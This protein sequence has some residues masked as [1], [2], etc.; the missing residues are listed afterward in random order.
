MGHRI[1]CCGEVASAVNLQVSGRSWTAR[2]RMGRLTD[3]IDQ[4]LVLECSAH[5]TSAPLVAWPGASP[6]HGR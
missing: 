5:H 2:E 4:H 6:F 1:G 3:H